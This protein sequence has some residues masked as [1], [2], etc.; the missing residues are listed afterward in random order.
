MDLMSP[1]RTLKKT[2]VQPWIKEIRNNRIFVSC[3][4]KSGSIRAQYRPLSWTHLEP[5]SEDVEQF[6]AMLSFEHKSEVEKLTKVLK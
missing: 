5:H 3:V 1:S 4:N 2:L 6:L